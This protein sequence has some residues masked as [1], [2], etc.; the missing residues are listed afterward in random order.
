MYLC[1]SHRFTIQALCKASCVDSS[2]QSWQNWT[3]QSAWGSFRCTPGSLGS[4]KLE[5]RLWLYQR[6]TYLSQDLFIFT[7]SF[8][9][10]I[11]S[12][13]LDRCEIVHVA[14]FL[15]DEKVVI[16][17]RCLT[18]LGWMEKTLYGDEWGNT[19]R[20]IREAGR[21]LEQAITGVVR[22][23]GVQSARWEGKH[24]SNGYVPLSEEW[25]HRR[26]PRQLW[27][28]LRNLQ[29][30]RLVASTDDKIIIKSPALVIMN[31]KWLVVNIFRLQ[32]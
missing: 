16:A 5:L 17:N 3:K 28:T 26:H 24:E 31:T 11:S 14:G 15:F 6:P 2:R 13:L 10:T 9:D 20:W 25:N 19:E 1:C 30:P 18:R 4:T 23:K 32:A 27:C 22:F 29:W 8:L 7:A 21:I 12:L